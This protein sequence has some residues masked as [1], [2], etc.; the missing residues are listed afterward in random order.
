MEAGG[1]SAEYGRA[2]GSSTNVIVKSGTNKFH[3]DGLVQH[4]KVKWGADNKDQP[5]LEQRESTQLP[6]DFLKKNEFQWQGESTGY[7]L[8]PSTFSVS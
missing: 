2:V 8:E 7:E 1:S 5:T 6:R 3:Y 4:Q